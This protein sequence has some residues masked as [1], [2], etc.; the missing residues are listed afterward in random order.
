VKT[1]ATVGFVGVTSICAILGYS[2]QSLVVGMADGEAKG[3]R[4]ETEDWVPP[5]R[6][7]AM[8]VEIEPDLEA[9]LL[10]TLESLKP[11]S[12]VAPLLVLLGTCLLILR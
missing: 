7:S 11:Q 9:P 3:E 1:T 8:G 10:G 2:A 6:M 5:R 12:R 4:D